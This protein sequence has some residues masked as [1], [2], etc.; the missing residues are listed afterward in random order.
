MFSS[1]NG[2][3]DIMDP[4]WRSRNAERLSG[5]G[6]R[7]LNSYSPSRQTRVSYYAPVLCPLG[8]SSRVRRRSHT[9]RHE[10]RPQKW[11]EMLIVVPSRSGSIFR[12]P[13]STPLQRNSHYLPPPPPEEVSWYFVLRL[14]MSFC[15]DALLDAASKLLLYSELRDIRR[16]EVLRRCPPPH[17]E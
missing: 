9:S 7:R 11:P 14:S 5:S 8:A 13:A 15:V 17:R 4:Q 3:M 10:V 16:H 6:H 1:K 12:V 2:K